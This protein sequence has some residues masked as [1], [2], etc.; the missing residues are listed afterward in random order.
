MRDGIKGLILR[1]CGKLIFTHPG[2]RRSCIAAATHSTSWIVAATFK[3]KVAAA[4]HELNYI[5]LPGLQRLVDC[6]GTAVGVEAPQ[7]KPLYTVPINEPE[8]NPWL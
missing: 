3:L 5:L 7:Y 1:H 8:L 4:I 6:G 2:S